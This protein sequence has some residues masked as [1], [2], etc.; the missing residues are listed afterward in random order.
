MRQ[1]T[2]HVRVIVPI[3]T[4]GFRRPDIMRALESPGVTVS[5]AEIDTVA[6]Q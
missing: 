3:T 2:V 5:H 4:R 1:D 6:H